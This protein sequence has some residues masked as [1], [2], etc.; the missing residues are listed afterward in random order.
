MIAANGHNCR[1]RSTAASCRVF[2][3][4]GGRGAADRA[5]FTAAAPAV[6]Q[7]LPRGRTASPSL[8]I[9]PLSLL[10]RQSVKQSKGNLS[11]V[12]GSLHNM[13]A[14]A[15]LPRAGH[16]PRSSLIRIFQHSPNGELL[17]T[18]TSWGRFECHAFVSRA[19]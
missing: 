4:V 7:M 13:P 18:V 3:F 17:F 16:M 19:T 14:I 2:A 9:S 11:R 5:T 12:V 8:A 1:A 10:S 15:G 6:P